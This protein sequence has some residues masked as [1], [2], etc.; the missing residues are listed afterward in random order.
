MYVGLLE[1]TQKSLVELYH[2]IGRVQLVDDMAEVDG[3]GDS[4][5]DDPFSSHPSDDDLFGSQSTVNPDLNEHG[6]QDAQRNVMFPDGGLTG[7]R[8]AKYPPIS[9]ELCE[10][11][12][13]N[14]SHQNF[15]WDPKYRGSK[16]AQGTYGTSPCLYT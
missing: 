4:D 14:G 6:R 2:V 16:E 8:E 9:D 5:D 15:L 7:R 11:Q 3:D 13:T 1:N 12:P 10:T